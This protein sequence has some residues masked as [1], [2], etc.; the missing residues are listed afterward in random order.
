MLIRQEKGQSCA[1][2]AVIA[3]GRCSLAAPAL[4]T[5]KFGAGQAK[6]A[7]LNPGAF[8]RADQ[9]IRARVRHHLDASQLA[10]FRGKRVIRSLSE[11]LLG[12]AGARRTSAL[13]STRRP[14]RGVAL[15]TARGPHERLHVGRR[16]WRCCRADRGLIKVAPVRSVQ[17]RGKQ[18]SAG[19]PRVPSSRGESR[20]AIHH[21][22]CLL[23]CRETVH[24]PSTRPARRA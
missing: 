8:Q 22:P 10:G 9:V 24:S 11:A 2:G 20:R 4:R 18:A 3:A 5:P 23:S 17:S 1:L 21:P 15:F 16:A 7:A 13:T 19:I 14:R 12:D 6:L